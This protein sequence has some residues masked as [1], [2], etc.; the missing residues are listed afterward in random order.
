[1]KRSFLLTDKRW[2]PKKAKF[3]NGEETHKFDR[4]PQ[5]YSIGPIIMVGKPFVVALE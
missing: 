1:M 5:S 2:K 3:H 4:E